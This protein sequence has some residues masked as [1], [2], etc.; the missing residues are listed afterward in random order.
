[1]SPWASHNMAHIANM[2]CDMSP[3]C[4]QASMS[5]ADMSDGGSRWHGTTPTIPTKGLDWTKWDLIAKN[6]FQT[7]RP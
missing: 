4:W 1:M 2:S 3:A 6:N 5:A 7:F